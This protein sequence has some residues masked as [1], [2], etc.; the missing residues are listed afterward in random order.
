MLPRERLGALWLWPALTSTASGGMPVS[1]ATRSRT[2]AVRSAPAKTRSIATIASDVRAVV[3]H[4]R[5]REQ[6]VVDALR[7]AGA[8]RPAAVRQ[9]ARR[10][11]VGA[12]DARGEVGHWLP[13]LPLTVGSISSS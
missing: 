13:F 12:R 10:S 11:D 5:L 3:D 4:E 1:A 8:E 9:A 6:R 7:E 2:A